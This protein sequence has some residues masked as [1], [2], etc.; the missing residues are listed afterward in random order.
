[1]KRFYCFPT[2]Q[3]AQL[4][5]VPRLYWREKVKADKLAMRKALKAKSGTHPGVYTHLPSTHPHTLP[6][7]HPD[8]G[9]PSH[10]GMPWVWAEFAFCYSFLPAAGTIQEKPCGG[11][12]HVCGGNPSPLPHYLPPSHKSLDQHH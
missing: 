1:M 10:R 5:K 8:A 3:R 7:T 6:D 12:T 2:I 9:M 11:R 4:D